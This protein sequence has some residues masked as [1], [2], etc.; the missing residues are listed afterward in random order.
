MNNLEHFSKK[1]QSYLDGTLRSD[2]VTE[3]EAFA[4]TSP[5][6]MKL[7]DKRIKQLDALKNQIPEVVLDSELKSQLNSETEEAIRNLFKPELNSIPE[8]VTH[9]WNEIF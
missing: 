9:W 4:S 7:V 6:L 2:E 3:F 1:I 8:K 5:E